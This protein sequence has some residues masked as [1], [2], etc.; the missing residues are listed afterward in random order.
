ML[1]S[2]GI[3]VN[4]Y[5]DD[6]SELDSELQQL[7]SQNWDSQN[8]DASS[9]TS[10]ND[11][12][13]LDSL[14]NGS[15]N[16]DNKIT[17]SLT[18]ESTTD[19]ISLTFKKLDK[20]SQYKVYYSKTSETDNLLEKQVNAEDGQE[21]VN[22]TVDNLEPNTEYQ[23]VVKAFDNDGNPVAETES[24]P[25]TASTK[26][27]TTTEP[28]HNAPSDNIIHDPV[29]TTN[30]TEVTISY[31]PWVDVSKVQISSSEDGQTFK[32]VATI[33]A[34]KTSYTFTPKTTWKKYIKI[35]PIAKD[36][37][38]WICR[39]GKT[40]VKNNTFTTSVEPK[41]TT[42][43]KIWKP[44]TGPEIYLLILFAIFAYIVYALRKRA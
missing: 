10:N 7:D 37:T 6:L 22:V 18:W 41:K 29:V 23:F 40:V 28:V 24:D 9:D 13:N 17:L 4:T 26:Q 12:E 44:K 33:D 11:L 31:K 32:P 39:V 15:T 2:I 3:I 19:S 20:Y 8:A 38:I 27:V 1:M 43:K 16:A 14:D 21:D 36:G 34:T 35:V 30:G 5:A 25:L 42:Q